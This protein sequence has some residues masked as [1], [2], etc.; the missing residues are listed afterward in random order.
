M[1]LALFSSRVLNFEDE[2]TF[3]LKV[4]LVFE[5]WKLEGASD[6]LLFPCVFVLRNWNGNYDC[7]FVIIIF[8]TLNFPFFSVVLRKK[9]IYI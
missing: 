6:A 3:Y 9:N 5:T 4:I 7:V 2:L 8:K 1:V